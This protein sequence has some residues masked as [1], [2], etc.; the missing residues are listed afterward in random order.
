VE[1]T[2]AMIKPDA[3][4]SRHIGYVISRIEEE[5]FIIERMSQMS[6]SEPSVRLLYEEHQ[7]K[8]FWHALLDFTLSSPVVLLQLTRENAVAHWRKV[9][10][11]TDPRNAEIGT[12]RETL[13]NK[14]GTI[15]RNVAHGSDSVASARRELAIF[16]V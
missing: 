10:G 1:T 8:V 15:Y 14:E 3:V 7:G 9:L 11:A 12:L 16:W 2:F 4:T 5:G 6:L 13:G